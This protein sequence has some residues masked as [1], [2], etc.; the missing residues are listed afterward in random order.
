MGFAGRVDKRLERLN[1]GIAEVKSFKKNAGM[2]MGNVEWRLWV[3][4]K[5]SEAMSFR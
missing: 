3:L 4:Y 1:T 5:K 2:V